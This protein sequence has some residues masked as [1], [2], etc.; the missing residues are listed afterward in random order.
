MSFD[1]N[2][3]YNPEATGLTKVAEVDLAEPCY[4][5]DLLA[6]FADGEGLYLATDSGCSCPTPF[7]DYNGKADM[8]GPLTVDQA[9]EEASSLKAAHYEP[10]YDLELWNAFI[11]QVRGYQ[12]GAV[13]S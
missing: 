12:H 1:T 4:S 13:T 5:F 6:V 8:T 3:Y 10:T 2:P 9:L 7:E 11:S